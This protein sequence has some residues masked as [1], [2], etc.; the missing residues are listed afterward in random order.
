M[1][2]LKSSRRRVEAPGVRLATGV[3][4]HGPC[5]GLGVTLMKSEKQKFVPGVVGPK[6]G[7]PLPAVP[8]VI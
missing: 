8:G 3:R 2:L 5:A 1:R 6:P 7:K 4:D